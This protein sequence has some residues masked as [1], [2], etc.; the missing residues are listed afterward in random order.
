M[1]PMEEL[2]REVERMRAEG[3]SRQEIELHVDLTIARHTQRMAKLRKQNAVG[4]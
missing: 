2:L 1:E 3:F 4:R